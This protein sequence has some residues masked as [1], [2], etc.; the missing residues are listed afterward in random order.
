MKLIKPYFEIQTDFDGVEVLKAIERYGRTCY[1]SEERIT[2]TSYIPFITSIMKRGHLSVI[3]HFSITV[4]FV[5]DRG[6]SHELVRHRLASFSQECLSG[7]T[8]VR[9]NKTIKHLYDRGKICYGKTHNKT[10]SLR[11]CNE[12][13]N[14][15]P[16]KMEDVFYKGVEPV[17]EV[18]TS[19]GYKIKTTLNHHFMVDENLFTPLGNLKVGDSVYINGRISLLKISDDD[20]KKLYLI[21]KLSPNE[22]AELYAIPYRSIL[23]RLK[24]LNIFTKHL[25]DKNKE[26]YNKNHTKQSYN[27]MR[28]TI[29]NQYKTGKRKTWNKGMIGEKSHNW[30]RFI[31]ED[32]RQKIS[33]SKLGEKNPRWNGGVSTY[34]KYKED[35]LHCE[36]CGIDDRFEIHHIDE[37]RRN[38]KMPNLIKV[39][40][41]CHNKLHHG[42]HIGKVAH[43]DKI[44]SIKFKGV[45]DVYDI[46]MKSP[47]NNFVANGFIVHNSTRYC[48]YKDEMTFIIPPWIEGIES[49]NYSGESIFDDAF[50]NL[51]KYD[52]NTITWLRVCISAERD[53]KELL[54]DGCLD[55]GWTP[56]QARSILPNSLKTEVVMSANL[57]EWLHVFN[58]R[59]HKASHPQIREIMTPLCKELQKRLPIIFDSVPI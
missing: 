37:N 19:L 9:K 16:N 7:D 46:E 23:R 42:W 47:H 11:S 53:Y 4:K 21:D 49:G 31:S 54:E 12:N 20:L 38:N 40:M 30:K 45:E 55:F 26:K 6:V 15:I 28:N 10:I 13:R 27:K 57:R 48:N 18:E 44:V 25:N 1:K 14:I 59:T 36:L 51:F 58:L 34:R 29:L 56:E 2:D 3:E 5:I 33:K 32:T 41:N 22:I 35:I 8:E 39:C 50:N 52:K 43:K 17:Y 24:K